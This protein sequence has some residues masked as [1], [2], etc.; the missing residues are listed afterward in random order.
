MT[1]DLM[2]PYAFMAAAPALADS[3]TPWGAR[4]AGE[5]RDV[6]VHTAEHSPR[7]MQKRLGPSELGAACD[8]QV[9]AKLAG[10]P[11]TNHVS[12]PWPSIVGTAVHAWLE[13]TFSAENARIGLQRWLTELRVYPTPQHPGSTDLYDRR[14]EAVV[15]WK[16]LGATTLAKI[17]RPSGPPRRYHVQLL[18]YGLGCLVA[19]LPVSRVVLIALP[20]TASTLNGMYVWDHPFGGPDDVALL[21]E[22]LRITEVRK[23]IAAE[24]IAGR[25]GINHIPITP[26]DAECFFCPFYRPESAYDNGPGCTGTIGNRNLMS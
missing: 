16:C 12:D 21:T 19:G 5:I 2:D 7:N 20:R 1:A 8:R 3:N 11:R 17:K 26:D 13:K 4:Y 22:V 9:I 25:I 10:I 14:E 6:I 24:V 15:D 23:Q 18:L